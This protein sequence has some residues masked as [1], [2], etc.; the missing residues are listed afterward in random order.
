MNK[1]SWLL[2]LADLAGGLKSMFGWL[3]VFIVVI[4][5][6]LVIIRLCAALNMELA[7]K[8]AALYGGGDKVPLLLTNWAAAIQHS[9]RTTI[10][11]TIFFVICFFGHFAM[12]SRE[13]VLG[14]AASEMGETALKT[15]TGNKAVAALNAW[16][17]RQLKPEKE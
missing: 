9:I 13:T 14:I 11:G 10:I 16:L 2:Y 15:E 17:D 8:Q 1:L 12:P 7:M 3:C 4:S 6:I 5:S